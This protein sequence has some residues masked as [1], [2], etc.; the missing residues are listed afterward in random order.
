MEVDR[1][2]QKGQPRKTW[3]VGVR[4]DMKSFGFHLHWT[5]TVGKG[6]HGQQVNP[7]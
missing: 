4:G 7:D 6:N 2:R 1:I 3:W 5:I